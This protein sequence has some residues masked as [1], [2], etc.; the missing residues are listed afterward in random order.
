[1]AIPA[2]SFHPFRFEHDSEPQSSAWPVHALPIVVSPL[3]LLDFL[4]PVE[5]TCYTQPLP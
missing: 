2:T 5:L 1:M 3:L 4:C